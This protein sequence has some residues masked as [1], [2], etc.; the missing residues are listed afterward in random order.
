MKKLTFKVFIISLFSLVFMSS[1]YADSQ[2]R[3]NGHYRSDHQYRNNNHSGYNKHRSSRSHDYGNRHNSRRAVR[4]TRTYNHGQNYSHHQHSQSCGHRV[5]YNYS[6][7]SYNVLN[8]HSGYNV[9]YVEY[10]NNGH[11][12]ATIV[13]GLVGGVIASDISHGNSAATALGAITGAAIAIGLDH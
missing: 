10:G 9:S 3:S 8:T 13:G 4:H 5:Y 12:A 11:A 6:D 2:Y 7:H 1:S